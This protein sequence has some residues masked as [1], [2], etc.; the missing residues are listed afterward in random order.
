M[1]ALA[2]HSFVAI[3]VVAYLALGVLLAIAALF[4]VISA[5][6]SLWGAIPGADS[7][8]ALLVSIDRMLLVLMIVEILHTVRASF[9]TG[10]LIC[11]PF[12]IVG[13]I[14]SIRRILIITLQSSQA[15]QPGRWSP[16]SQII[17]HSTML[18]LAVLGGLILVMVLSIYLLRRSGREHAV[19]RDQ[20]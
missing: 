20:N 14:A 19:S 7:I 4:G 6:L 15:S 3:E 9:R 11:E 16:E 13:L 18:E 8:D 12:L 10:T 17:L 2:D 1:V 5:G